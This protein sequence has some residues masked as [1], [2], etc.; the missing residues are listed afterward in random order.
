LI[1]L[2]SEKGQQSPRQTAEIRYQ[3]D[4]HWQA[5]TTCHEVAE[6]LI[7]YF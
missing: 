5:D 3:D 4:I 7:S 2:C 6:S 1:N